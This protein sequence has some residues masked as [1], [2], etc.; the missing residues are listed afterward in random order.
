V[1]IKLFVG[2]CQTV[3]REWAADSV[4]ACVTDPP[5]GLSF[6]GKAWDYDVPSADIWREVYRVLKPG[7][8]LLAFFG[9]R[10]Y[11]RGVV[12]IED[13]GFE[14]RD[15]IMWVYGSG[16]PKSLD[17]GKA[18]DKAGGVSPR[19]QSDLL[20]AKRERA[21]LSRD[22]VAAHVGCTSASVRDWEEG[23]AR[24][25]GA[26]LEWI[27]PSDQYRRALAD[28]LGYSADERLIAGVATDRAGDETVIGLGHSG[29]LRTG[30]HTDAAKQW[31][32]WGTAL[33][34]AHEPIVVAR[35]PLIGT[36][37]ENVQ[38]HGTGAINID[39]SRVSTNDKL[40]GGDQS[41]ETK[42]KVDGWDRPWMQDEAAKAA[43]AARVNHN[44]AKAEEL[45]RWPANV[46]H[47]GSEEVLSC[48]P[49]APGQMAD[50][51]SSSSRSSQNVYGSM[52]K[53]NG[54]DGEPSAERDNEGA[55]GFKMKP[56]ARREDAGSA[57]RF[58]YCAKASKQDRDEGLDNIP[59]KP[60]VTFQTANGTS[61]R[62][63]SISEGRETAYRNTH[64]TV[65]PTA[66]MRYLIKL[67]TPPGGMVLD[68]FMG[69]GSTGKAAHA[70]GFSFAGIERDPQWINIAWRRI[71]HDSPL[72][73]ELAEKATH[74]PGPTDSP[75]R[76]DDRHHDDADPQLSEEASRGTLL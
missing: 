49:D 28:L 25:V 31:E 7:A 63:S 37:A 27:T 24:A 17:V 52:K 65:K 32:G 53:G 2:D 74:A 6:M 30:G 33:K 68:P 8:H 75:L 12:Q 61:G 1:S 42:I 16:F 64:P 69:S 54:R 67:V 29:V 21:G 41:A 62:A 58:F 72:F 34:P 18:I 15:Q 26:S 19:A 48:F 56:G 11:H 22:Q 66:L 46:I 4:D 51:S 38:R 35:K 5:Y 23:R 45:G 13:A 57:A 44:V 39:A 71:Y 59:E 14:I 36:V 40:G 20:K 73:A 76:A 55:V 47:D 60:V 70:E 50:A 3:L 9:S 43:H 10:T